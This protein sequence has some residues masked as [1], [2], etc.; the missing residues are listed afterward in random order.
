MNDS[1]KFYFSS[2]LRSWLEQDST[3]PTC[4]TTLADP[5]Q[6][7]LRP[8]AETGAG[9]DARNNPPAGAHNRTINHYF[10]FDG[11]CP[12]LP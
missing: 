1:V 2:C 4:R 10:Q 8:E 3:C 12:S 5:Q 6:T 9:G 7:V 11:K